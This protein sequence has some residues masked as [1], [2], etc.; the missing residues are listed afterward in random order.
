[1]YYIILYIKSL[2]NVLCGHANQFL[3]TVGDLKLVGRRMF[4]GHS[5]S[6]RRL[7]SVRK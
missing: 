2:H 7:D 6:V 5:F 3:F 1:M 4:G